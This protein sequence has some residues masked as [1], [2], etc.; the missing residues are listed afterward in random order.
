MNTWTY[1]E[2]LGDDRLRALASHTFVTTRFTLSAA[3]PSP[4]LISESLSSPSAKVWLA[5]VGLHLC[6]HC[7]GEWS[8]PHDETPEIFN[9]V[10]DLASGLEAAWGRKAPY[11]TKLKLIGAFLNDGRDE[12]VPSHKRFRADLLHRRGWA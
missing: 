11:F 5:E 3:T 2:S 1:A 9:G 6:D 12:F 4:N 10:W 8:R 7:C